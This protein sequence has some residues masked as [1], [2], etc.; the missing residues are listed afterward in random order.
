MKSKLFLIFISILF[1]SQYT[2]AA[3]VALVVNNSNSLDDYHE[4]RIKDILLGLNHTITLVDKNSNASIPV[5]D[6]PTIAIDYYYVDDWDWTSNPGNVQLTTVYAYDTSN[7]IMNGFSGSVTVFVQAFVGRLITTSSSSTNMHVV[8]SLTSQ[9]T[10][11]AILVA[12]PNTLL[13]NGKITKNR[14]VFFGIA[15]P[16]Y[17]NSNA[18]NMFKNSVE[19]TIGDSD[20]DGIKNAYD[21]CQGTP[22][23]I[24][25]DEAG[26]SCQQKTCNDGNACTD[27]TCDLNTAQCIFA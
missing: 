23:N 4:D 2:I 18:V 26:C 16:V 1:I 13:E 14:I 25:I 11:G 20:N 17:W 3:K 6:V 5:N 27:D 9:G 10:T 15:Y 12:E 8:G 19:W 22:V 24:T 21:F 7:S